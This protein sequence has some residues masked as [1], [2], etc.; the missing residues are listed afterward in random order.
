MTRKK[1]KIKAYCKLTVYANL[2]NNNEII[3][4]EEIDEIDEI[5]GDE[6]LI[7]IIH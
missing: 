4:I 2:G 5:L 1:I 7:D 3:D 6:E